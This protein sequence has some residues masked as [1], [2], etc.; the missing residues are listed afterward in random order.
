MSSPL[1]GFHLLCLLSP[2]QQALRPL[3]KHFL[4]LDLPMF[5]PLSPHWGSQPLHHLDRHWF[6]PLS[7][8]RV[9]IFI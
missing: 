1:Q 3:S 8:V 4:W 2:Q 5:P 6:S 7:Q 9:A